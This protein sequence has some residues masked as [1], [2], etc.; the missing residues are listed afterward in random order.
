M[1][2]VLRIYFF[3]CLNA[4]CFLF[5]FFFFTKVFV[6]YLTRNEDMASSAK[7]HHLQTLFESVSDFSLGHN[8]SDVQYKL[9]CA[10]F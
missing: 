2:E 1:S 7:I 4:S 6:L 5:F 9:V 3:P 8:V 10:Y